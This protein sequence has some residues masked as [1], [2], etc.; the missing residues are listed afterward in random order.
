MSKSRRK[1]TSGW[2][3]TR[4]KIILQDGQLDGGPTKA[5]KTGKT[6]V[7]IQCLQVSQSFLTRRRWPTTG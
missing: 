1:S 2:I 3:K 6:K 4:L 7:A 5:N